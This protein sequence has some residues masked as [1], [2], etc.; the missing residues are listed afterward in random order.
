LPRETKPTPSAFTKPAGFLR[1]AALHAPQDETMSRY[2][3]LQLLLALAAAPWTAG[4]ADEPAATFRV[5][6]AKIDITPD[7]TAMTVTLNGYGGR[8]KKPATGILDPVYAR[9]VVVTDPDGRSVAVVAADLCYINT[10][11]H[12][13]VV[14]RLAADGFDDHNLMIAAIHNHNGP[15]AY[16]RRWLA[17]ALMGPFDQ[18]ILDQVVDGIVQAVRTAAGRRQAAT[19]HLVV[20]EL[21]G[22]NRSRRDPAF[23]VAVGGGAGL[24]TDPDLYPTDRK[25]T[26]LRAD[27]IDGKPLGLLVHFASHPTVLS[28]DNMLISA[29]WPGVMNSELEKHLG[30]GAI[31]VFVNGALGDAAPLP[32]WSTP[33]QEV[34]QV[35]QYGTQ[36]ADAVRARLDRLR[37]VADPHVAGFTQR[38]RFDRVKLN[39][40]G[41]MPLHHG[42]TKLLV[43]RRDQPVQAVRIGRLVLF[44]VPGEPTTLT[45]Q[46]FEELCRDGFVC[47][48]TGLANGHLG[49]FVTPVEYDEG[50]YAPSSCLWGRDTAARVKNALRPAAVAAQARP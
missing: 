4:A 43:L 36:M 13:I 27:D 37:P 1:G 32:D 33:E 22:M 30:H 26:L 7:P 20:D 14:A 16:D 38:A 48:T 9:A 24:A 50:G 12:D 40:S 25:L 2:L 41:G 31:S 28:P 5:G 42:M 35:R 21:P 44:G 45:G 34:V 10:D 3:T 6:F 39:I 17:G 29:D 15:S 8:G 47:R 46:S 11:V 19:L 23:D 49:Y 18:R